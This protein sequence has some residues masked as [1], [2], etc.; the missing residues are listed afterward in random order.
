LVL[1]LAPDLDSVATIRASEEWIRRGLE[2]VVDNAAQAMLD[3]ASAHRQLTARTRL[4][5]GAVEILV[6]DTG[7]GIPEG[8]KDRLFREP[9]DKP[10]GS[11]GAGI[12]LLLARTIFE[13]YQGTI[14]V[15]DTGPSGTQIAI[16]LPVESN[17]Q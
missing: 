2:I 16:R 9:V 11:R 7:P 3:Q 1:D 12:G 4:K 6:R 13:T 14:G 15:F 5:N 10:R 17:G 8:I